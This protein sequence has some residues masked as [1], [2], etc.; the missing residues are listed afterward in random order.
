M[1]NTQRWTPFMSM[2]VR[3]E[4]TFWKKIIPETHFMHATFKKLN[5]AEI[6]ALEKFMHFIACEFNIKF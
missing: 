4:Q 3:S 2:S 1:W 6:L 5:L